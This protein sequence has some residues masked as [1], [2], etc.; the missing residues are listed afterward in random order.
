MSAPLFGTPDASTKANNSADE[1]ELHKLTEALHHMIDSKVEL[2]SNVAGQL[3]R[4]VNQR[5]MGVDQNLTTLKKATESAVN[6]GRPVNPNISIGQELLSAAL[7]A[8]NANTNTDT[9][10]PK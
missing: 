8:G 5:N 1:A 10:K 4:D 3:D 2:N 7:P 9:V 6:A